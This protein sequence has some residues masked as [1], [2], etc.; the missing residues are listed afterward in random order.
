[1]YQSSEYEAWESFIACPARKFKAEPMPT[2]SKELIEKR[3]IHRNAG[4]SSKVSVASPNVS[5]LPGLPEIPSG[6]KSNPRCC[7]ATSLLHLF[8]RGAF[9]Q[10]NSPFRL[11]KRYSEHMY[12]DQP[13]V[14]LVHMCINA[15]AFSGGR[16][17]NF[18]LQDE[19]AN[20]LVFVTMGRNLGR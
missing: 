6:E 2:G 11:L 19:I 4:T 3:R 20:K 7:D 15:E 18:S 5:M 17:P 8:C 1:M 13:F 10:P 9:G 12:N 14:S 16:E